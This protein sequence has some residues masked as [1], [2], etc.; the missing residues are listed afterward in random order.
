MTWCRLSAN[1]HFSPWPIQAGLAVLRGITSLVILLKTRVIRLFGVCLVL[2]GV[3]V[4]LWRIDI[5]WEGER[6][7]YSLQVYDNL[8]LS[9]SLLVLREA[10]LL[11]SFFWSFFHLSLSP[12]PLVGHIWPPLGV[13][14]ILP[15][16]VPLLNTILLI[17]RGVT[18][19]WGHHLLI[20]GLQVERTTALTR[21]ILLGSLFLLNQGVEF[22]EAIF[23]LG[24]SAYGRVFL[25]LTGL[26]GFHVLLGLL[27][28]F[29][30][31]LR[32]LWK[33][34]TCTNHAR[35]EMSI[36]YWHLVDCVWLVVYSFIYWWGN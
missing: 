28:L 31:Q 36:W 9:F 27:L 13:E 12:A 1:I 2:F 21:T 24:E 33:Q 8:K 20:C 29:I 14:T 15:R 11:F 5:V 16:G 32:L 10:M 34:L 19:T 18:V 30:G 25:T 4:S 22:R 23:S 3:S 26:H 7:E 17:R 35:L 6:G